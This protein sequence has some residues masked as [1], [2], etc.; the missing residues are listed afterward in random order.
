L[1]SLSQQVFSDRITIDIDAELEAL[2]NAIDL[3]KKD[4]ENKV[5]SIK[6]DLTFLQRLIDKL[7]EQEFE[8]SDKYEKAKYIAF[9]IMK[10]ERDLIKQRFNP[11]AKKVTLEL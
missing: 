1:K 4:E 5:D 11:S 2:I 7:Q 6:N 9:K 10:E 8:A 3:E